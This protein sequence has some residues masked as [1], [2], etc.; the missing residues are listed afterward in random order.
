MLLPG[1]ATDVRV[2]DGLNLPGDIIYPRGMLTGDIDS[3]A[4]VLSELKCVPALLLGWSLGGFAAAR[5]ARR[6]P[7]LVERVVLVGIR[8][9]YPAGQLARMRQALRRD[10][11]CCLT[12]F[13]RQCFLPVQRA[14]YRCF[15]AALEQV[16]ISE[17]TTAELEAGLDY[18][19]RTTLETD[20]IPSGTTIVHGARDIIAPPAE[21]CRLA[22]ESGAVL[23]LLPEAGHAAFLTEEFRSICSLR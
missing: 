20:D 7:A 6:Y 4:E 1:W 23:H 17:F 19:G 11:A 12:D 16:Y 18:L 15:R 22:G 14:A 10:R 9:R 2:F 13:Y 3:L 8:N 5:F 21:A